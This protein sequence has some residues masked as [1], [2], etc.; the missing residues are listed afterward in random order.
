[1]KIKALII[2]VIL[3]SLCAITLA[4]EPEDGDGTE[5]TAHHWVL[6]GQWYSGDSIYCQYTNTINGITTVFCYPR[7]VGCASHHQE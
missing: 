7:E 3:L 2:I 4:D 1:M 5:M 6:V